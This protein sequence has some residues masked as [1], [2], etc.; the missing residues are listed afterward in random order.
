MRNY[1]VLLAI[2]LFVSFSLGV[3]AKD[4]TPDDLK[5]KKGD[6]PKGYDL[7]NKIATISPKPISFY[8]KPDMNDALPLPEKKEFQ[9]FVEKGKAR[10]TI[11]YFQYKTPKDAEKVKKYLTG[12]LWGGSKKPS[13]DNPEEI[14]LFD[15]LVMVLCFQYQSDESLHIRTF[16]SEKK[17]FDL[18]TNEEK[19]NKIFKTA[20]EYLKNKKLK[21][22]IAFMNKN[23]EII[24]N[25]SL[26]ELLFAEFYYSD[27]DYDNS[28]K[29][30]KLA[31]DLH[32]KGKKLPS[33]SLLFQT[34]YGLGSSLAQ[35]EKNF[36][37]IDPFKKALDYAKKTGEKNNIA[38]TA[39]E[40]AR[41]YC[42]IRKFN[43][44]FPYLKIAIQN[45]NELK[46]YALQDGTFREA[47]EQK[48][49]QELLK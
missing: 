18:L 43:D 40:L 47:R 49:F 24:K 21:D 28:A 46:S 9:E 6:L 14:F 37:T 36:E 17:G 2:T 29:H 39:Y 38:V 35:L 48:N 5:L 19:F 16:L 27:K 4:Y 41:S 12:F 33:D 34:F 30:Y 3:Y 26:G 7:G 22:G 45:D 1:I 15:N 8:E 25:F 13:N 32:N 10:G 42:R 23:N 44:A 11:M 31:G 20:S